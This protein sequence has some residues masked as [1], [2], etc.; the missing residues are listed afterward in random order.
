MHAFRIFNI[1]PRGEPVVFAAIDAGASETAFLFGHLRAAK[2]EERSLGHEKMIEHI[3]PSVETWLGAERL[4][5]RLAFRVWTRNEFAMNE[6]KIPMEK[7]AEEGG[8]GA[9]EL[10]SATCPKRAPTSRSCGRTVIRPLSRAPTRKPSPTI[11]L[12][13]QDRRTKL[14][15]PVEF[16][17]DEMVAQI[18]AWID[19]GA[20]AFKEAL[21]AALERIGKGPDP[22]DGVRVLLGGRFGM[23]PHWGD[24]SRESS[25]RT[26]RFTGFGSRTRRTSRRRR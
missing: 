3:E 10:S 2:L 19:E 12:L 25:R 9:D 17:R 14:D 4:L 21:R 8:E 22:F 6:A 7:P 1:Q 20:K 15:V 26:S 11:R 5:H 18:H 23:H 13:A 24:E 16:D